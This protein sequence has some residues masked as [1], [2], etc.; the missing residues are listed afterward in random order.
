MATTVMELGE[1]ALL[2]SL[3]G[4]DSYH[5]A[6]PQSLEETG[7][8]PVVIESLIIKYLAAGRLGERSRDCRRDCACRSAFWRT[9]CWR[10]AAGSS[11]CTRGSRS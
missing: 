5:P 7:L 11:W 1:G 2:E 6:E 3:L 9:C 8:S 10:C 4:G